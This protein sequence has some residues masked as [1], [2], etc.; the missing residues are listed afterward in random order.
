MDKL[1]SMASEFL[2]A[3]KKERYSEAIISM[4]ESSR[5]IRGI[6]GGLFNNYRESILALSP[7]QKDELAQYIFDRGM[8]LHLLFIQYHLS[9]GVQHISGIAYDDNP[10]RRSYTYFSALKYFNEEF[11]GNSDSAKQPRVVGRFAVYDGGKA[12]LKGQF[13]R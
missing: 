9:N 13:C 6:S 8:Q 5:G 7:E 12:N 2:D 4:F 10:L 11:I 3:D 1:E